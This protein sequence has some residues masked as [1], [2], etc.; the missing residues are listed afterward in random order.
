MSVLNAPSEW[1]ALSLQ[2][3]FY[4]YRKAKAD[5]FHERTVLVGE[6]F[7][8]FESKLYENLQ[9]LHQRLRTGE[10]DAVISQN[11][12]DHVIV[13]KKLGKHPEP[14][15]KKSESPHDFFSDPHRYFERLKKTN[16]LT[17][18]FR[19]V[20]DFSVEA[21]IISALWIN[22]VGHKFDAQLG[23]VAYGA[24]L[25]RYRPDAGDLRGKKGD[26][27]MEGLGSFEPYFTPY[28]NWRAGGLSAMRSELEA[29]RPVIAISLDLASYYHN[30]DPSFL[31]NKNFHKAVGVTLTK[32]EREFTNSIAL[33][34][35]TWATGATKKLSSFG[36]SNTK[37]LP[38]GLPIGLTA[39]RIIANVLLAPLDRQ[40]V[41]GITPVYYGRYV[42]DM[43]LVIRDPETL[44]NASEL[45][46][47]IKGRVDW[48]RLDGNKIA[49]NVDDSFAGKSNIYLQTEKQKV[50]FLSGSSGIDLLSTIESEIGEVSSERRLL[51]DP[52]N[53]E[54]MASAKVLA[55]GASVSEEVDTL[56]RADGLSVRRLGWSILLRSVETLAKDL[57]PEDWKKERQRFYEFAKEHILR[58]DRLFDHADYLPRLLSIC[59]TLEDWTASR[60]IWLSCLASLSA[61]KAAT[62]NGDSYRYKL[63][64]YDGVSKNGKIWDSLTERLTLICAESI[65]RSLRCTVYRR[66][67]DEAALFSALKL[68]EDRDVV[69]GRALRLRET[70]WSRVPYK[71]HIRKH[72]AEPPNAAPKQDRLLRLYKFK[73]D[74]IDF[75]KSAATVTDGAK[76]RRTLFS[77]AADTDI[78]YAETLLPYLFPTRPYTTSEIA[79]FV[80][81]CIDSPN[82]WARCVRALRGAWVRERMGSG[83]TKSDSDADFP[84]LEVGRPDKGQRVTLGVTSLLTGVDSWKASASNRPDLSP[85]RYRRLGNLVKQA[86]QTRPAPT[87]LLLPELSL[88]EDWLS[89]ITS[90][91]REVGISLIA[92]LEYQHGSGGSTVH[93]DA[94][95]VLSDDRL[96]FPSWVELRQPKCQPAPQEEHDLLRD[97]GKT[98]VNVEDTQKAIYNHKGFYFGV[99]VCSELQN[100]RYRKQFQG[101]VDCVMV[102]SWNQDLE[103]FSALVE[104]AALDVHSY[105]ALV[106]NRK[107]GDSRVRLPAKESFNRDICRLRGGKNDYLVVVDLDLQSLRAFQ[108]RKKRWPGKDD[109]FKPVPE[110]F[111]ILSRRKC[112]PS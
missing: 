71:E 85:D 1:K 9:L 8:E 39:S 79:L 41:S 43:F 25:R 97:F 4:A 98:W 28:K 66:H 20:G 16:T 31:S 74:L 107:Y 110:G 99:L 89:S 6:R 73:S 34:L 112:T 90:R 69:R 10:I 82:L 27:H 51:P 21:H 59:V 93:S 91:L 38:G 26:Y 102:L 46:E 87:H 58:P 54:Q 64:G 32:W 13:A 53:L 67:P 17:P 50:F 2:H 94:V 84:I 106:N 19:V 88:P 45:F 62:K 101:N 76:P 18:E 49:V 36:V 42:D 103:T 7:A 68:G 86:V 11:I 109:P 108:S 35:T 30:I 100:I 57:R 33:W 70:D 55:A 23:S 77:Y 81:K 14:P 48:L 22:L 29:K 83:K 24:R 56:R 105:I 37:D 75:L 78:Q 72:A 65:L 63:N 104:S 61:L 92:G 52:D 111:R 60:Q 12:G 44:E 96:G 95:L 15:Q 40:I 47:W 80:P 5:C 3:L